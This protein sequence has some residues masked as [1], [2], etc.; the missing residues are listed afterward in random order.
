MKW[1]IYCE[2]TWDAFKTSVYEACEK[3]LGHCNRKRQD[4]FDENDNE[5]QLL[6]DIKS[7]ALQAVLQGGKT[8]DEHRQRMNEFKGIKAE[9]QRKL[10]IMKDTWWS[11]KANEI[12][13]AHD[14]N[15]TKL[16]YN[17]LREVYGPSSSSIAPLRSKDGNNLL[18]DPEDIL[19]RWREHFD[20]LL[21]RPYE[22]NQEF[23]DSIPC[24]SV[25]EAMADVP[26]IEE[27][28][29][30]V[31]KLNYGKSPGIDGLQAGLI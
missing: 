10:R 4:W 8:V 1:K 16:L 30:A 11:N 6:L 25:K 20:E 23:I 2:T 18:R 3:V 28:K 17:L 27:V 15:N 29:A 5:I 26:S 9:V 19:K 22:V 13:L 21:N 31:S 7:K 14:T 12:Q 24:S